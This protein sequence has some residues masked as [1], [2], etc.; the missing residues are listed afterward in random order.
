M[1]ALR[2]W[3]A[4]RSLRER[5]LLLVAAALAAVTLLWGAVLRPLGDALAAATERQTDAAVR[6]ADT[7]AQ[8]AALRRIDRVRGVAPVVA[9]AD[10]VRA[11]AA[12]AGFTLAALDPD[13]AD[14]VRVAIASA[15]GGAVVGWLARL[16]R[17][18]VIVEG[19]KL[20][21]H[22]DRTVAVDLT[23]GARGR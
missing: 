12:E 4:G 10:T 23:L 19:A 15:K 22:G 3:F 13:G 1:T 14:R 18:G 8:V 9:L 5:R 20:T 11:E 2:L 6:L 16:E 7:R 17:M 21:D